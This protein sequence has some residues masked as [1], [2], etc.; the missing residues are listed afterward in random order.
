MFQKIAL[1]TFHAAAQL[2][3]VVGLIYC[4]AP[5]AFH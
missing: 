4:I 1:H 3:I 5:G 2:G